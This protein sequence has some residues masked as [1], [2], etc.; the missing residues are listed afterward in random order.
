[1]R[2]TLKAA[3][4]TLATRISSFVII[5]VK[6]RVNAFSALTHSYQIVYSKCEGQA[7]LGVRN[8]RSRRLK[9]P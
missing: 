3:S 4:A 2:R 1:M 9:H 8:R 7:L 5:D 6:E